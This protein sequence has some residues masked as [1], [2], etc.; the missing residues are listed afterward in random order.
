LP[1]AWIRQRREKLNRHF[2][3]LRAVVPTVSR[4]D[5]ASLLADAA[6]R[7][8][9]LEPVLRRPVAGRWRWEL[10]IAASS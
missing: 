3:D 1:A 9:W 10:P 4:M 6:A 8:A 5:K 7:V 2:C